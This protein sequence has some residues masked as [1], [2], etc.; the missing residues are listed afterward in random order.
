MGWWAAVRVTLTNPR[1]LRSEKSPRSTEES[2]MG[3]RHPRVGVVVGVI[4]SLSAVWVAGCSD[5]ITG[6][7]DPITELPRALSTTELALIGAGNTIQLPVP[8][9][10]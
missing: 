8:G 2:T 7:A 4:L 5:G 6:P 9:S 3:T 1:S 10:R